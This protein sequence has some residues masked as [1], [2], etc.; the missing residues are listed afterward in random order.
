MR[1]LNTAATGM[2]AQQL[3]VEVI[4]NNIANMNTT[5][6]KRQR[7]E[8]QDLL[9][10]NIERMG[11]SS[12]DGGTIV[13]TGVQ[14]GVGVKAGSVYRVTE[15]GNIN[16][17]GNPYDLA[18]QG[19]GY[20]I[21]QMPDGRDA[22]T[23][24]GNF[25]LS[26]EGQIVTEDGFVVAPGISVPTDAVAVSINREGVV[27]AVTADGSPPQDVGA[28]ELARFVNPPGLE[29]IGENLFLE[30]AASGPANRGQPGSVGFGTMLQ[31]FL[32]TSNVNAVSEI[33]SLITAQRAY[34]MN[35]KVITTTDEMLRTASNLR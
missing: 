17:S 21:V 3:N 12:S 29:A 9:Y 6:F 8:F 32:E 15:Q 16:Q 35:S 7:A 22:Y 25:A 30:T 28:F 4:A 2:Q 27:Q 13:P 10:Q 18:L 1:A 26:A 20:F 5:G 14:V 34:E 19:E 24:A 31:G 33:S 11:V 23:R